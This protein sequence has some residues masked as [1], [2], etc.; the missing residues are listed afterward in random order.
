M[1]GVE[2]HSKAWLLRKTSKTALRTQMEDDGKEGVEVRARTTR[3]IKVRIG[4]RIGNADDV[5][6]LLIT[7]L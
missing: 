6:R 7:C 3:S 1:A 5:E 2:K 4:G